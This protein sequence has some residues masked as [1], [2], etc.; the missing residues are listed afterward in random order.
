MLLSPQCAGCVGTST[1]ALG[2]S[3]VGPV[4]SLSAL[5]CTRPGSLPP[6]Q[7]SGCLSLSVLALGFATLGLA[8]PMHSG[9]ARLGPTLP[10]LGT[11]CSGSVFAVFVADLACLGVPLPMRRLAC[12]E[13]APAASQTS[14]PEASL[15]L[16]SCA[17][18]DLSSSAFGATCSGPPLPAPDLVT[19]G[20]LPLVQSF[21]RPGAFSLTFGMG[22]SD[23]S[24]VT[25][26]LLACGSLLSSRQLSY[27]GFLPF[28]SSVTRCD[29]SSPVLDVAE[30]ELSL[31]PRSF[32]HLG[33]VPSLFGCAAAE[34]SPSVPDTGCFGASPLVRNCVWLGMSSLVPGMNCFG[35][36]TVI[37]DVTSTGSFLLMQRLARLGLPSTLCS[38]A[39]SGLMVLVLD[40]LFPGF[41]FALRSSACP[42]SPL[43]V[44]GPATPDAPLPAIDPSA[45]STSPLRSSG[46]L[47]A[48]PIVLC[49]ACSG[50]S[51]PAID[52]ATPDSL[53]P[54]RSSSRLSVAMPVPDLSRLDSPI[55]LRAPACTDPL[56]LSFAR[57]R[58]GSFSAVPDVG[59]SG[60]F[61]LPR[62]MFRADFVL[63]LLRVASTALLPLACDM[64]GSDFSP[65]FQ[66]LSYLGMAASLV[67]L[68]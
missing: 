26:D 6:P 23:V 25:L 51:M 62:N 52:S 32:G 28:V 19:S 44:F 58:P 64:S 47:D 60:A 22:C 54:L 18:S 48:S 2:L 53:L 8:P 10:V 16:H 37:L 20:M 7:G 39:R 56:L 50:L 68:A 42:G 59:I 9:S 29:S 67:G 31:L 63:P 5:D 35:T 45:G 21:S 34:T 11:A 14:H 17:S 13:S 66:S 33:L 41:S 30:L 61:L 46:K 38:A 40:S 4:F 43:A 36:P 1:P 57:A 49:S 24:L 27:P 3:C 12:P 65:V 55:L 15:L